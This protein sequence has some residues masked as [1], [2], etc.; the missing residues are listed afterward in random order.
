MLFQM[1]ERFSSSLSP[2]GYRWCPVIIANIP[3]YCALQRKMRRLNSVFHLLLS[4]IMKRGLICYCFKI[5]LERLWSFE[6]W[7]IET[8]WPL[9]KTYLHEA[10]SLTFPVSRRAFSF[11]SLDPVQVSTALLLTTLQPCIGQVS[12]MGSWLPGP[13]LR[14]QLCS[15]VPCWPWCS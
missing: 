14:F 6:P 8:L 13:Q 3:N 15:S 1:S 5:Q 2:I 10:L 4:F 7:V 9:S 11:T 12:N